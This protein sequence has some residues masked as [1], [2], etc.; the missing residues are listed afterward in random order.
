MSADDWGSWESAQERSYV[1][2]LAATPDERLAW[3]EEMLEIALAA[4]A[5]PKPRDPWGRPL[6][7]APVSELGPRITPP[8]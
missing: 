6:E 2:G 8:R 7:R 5:I 3:L 1:R 4:A